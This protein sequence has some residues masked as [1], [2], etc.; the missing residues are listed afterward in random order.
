M[1]PIHSFWQKKIL[2]NISRIELAAFLG[3]YVFFS[4]MYTLALVLSTSNPLMERTFIDYSLKMIYSIP[5]WWLLFRKL[6]HW[7][8]KSRLLIHIFLCP[9]YIFVWLKTYHAVIDYFELGR[10]RGAGMWWDVYIPFL[11]YVV[12]F[13]IIHSYDFWKKNEAQMEREK[14]LIQHMHKSELNALK[15]Q[16]QPHFLFNTLN[17]ISATV[18]AELEH[19]RELIAKL[20]DTFRYTLKASREDK[21]QL[22]EEIR[23]IGD[24][25]ALEQQ[26]FNDR[27]TVNIKVDPSLNARYIPPMLLQPLVENAVMHGIAKNIEGGGITINVTKEENFMHFSIEDTGVGHDGQVT[28]T[29]L[30]KGVGLFNTH[31]RLLKLYN[32][33]I[34]ISQNKPQGTVLRFRIPITD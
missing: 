17:S 20:A 19:T 7:P 5:I 10:L 2:W 3:V 31:Q 27:L 25:L 28:A 26:R 18:P 21:I 34:Q 23:F 6:R 8:D 1:Q 30:Q 13:G 14:E 22:Q 29:W 11:F 24:C 4:T 16:I 12:Q 33:P 15:A 9:L 32:E